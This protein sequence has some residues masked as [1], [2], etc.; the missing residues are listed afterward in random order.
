M[1]KYFAVIKN[2][3]VDSIIVADEEFLKH[4]KDNYHHIVDVTNMVRPKPGDTYYPK[5]NSFVDNH[6]E[7]IEIPSLNPTPELTF[8]PFQLSKYS[9]HH[10]NGYIIIGCKKYSSAGFI[11]ALKKIAEEKVDV[12][13]HFSTLY[14]GPGHGKFNITWDDVQKLYDV[15]IK[16]EL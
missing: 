10:E 15:I 9:V 7:I 14:N 2:H 12:T 16:G 3:L 4:I 1:T 6:I 11:D 8:E 13:S 5:T